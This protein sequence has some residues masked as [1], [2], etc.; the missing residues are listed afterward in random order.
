MGTASPREPGHTGMKSSESTTESG[1]L[2]AER[3]I[4]ADLSTTLAVESAA[5]RRK[6]RIKVWLGRAA[7]LVIIF[8]GWQAATGIGLVDTVLTSTPL[9]VLKYLAN[10]V[11][12]RSLQSAVVATLTASIEGL[13]IGSII[14]IILALLLHEL[15]TLAKATRPYITFANSLP[16]PPLAPIFLVWFGLGLT[17]KV[18]LSISI[19]LFVMLITTTGGLQGT[20]HD[21]LLLSRSMGMSR[22]QRLFRIEVPASTPSIMS[23]LRISASYSV[24]GVVISELVAASTG[25]GQLLIQSTNSFNIAASFGLIII[26]GLIATALDQLISLIEHRLAWSPT[27]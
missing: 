6:L 26:V 24:L 8:G 5:R 3:A 2:D 18:V 12:D 9:D 4:F 14:G 13:V 22:V 15:P 27:R 19:V 20:N 21:W 25:L 10:A 17:A 11:T 7:V 16:R 23:G 1:R